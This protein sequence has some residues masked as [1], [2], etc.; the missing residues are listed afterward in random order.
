MGCDGFD[1]EASDGIDDTQ[2]GADRPLGVV[3]MRSR[4]AEINQDPVTHIFCDKA[5]EA[6]DDICHGAVIGGD[7]L[8]QIFRIEPRRERGRADEVAE[9]HR[10][11][12]ALGLGPRPSLPRLRRRG[13]L[14]GTER[15]NGVEHPPPMPN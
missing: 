6:A 5:V 14:L 12:A 7:D 1:I 2:P 3:F 4:V 10:Q 8:A 9:H 15:G 11:L 13:R